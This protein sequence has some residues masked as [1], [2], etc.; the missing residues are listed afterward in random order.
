LRLHEWHKRWK[1]DKHRKA[2]PPEGQ[3]EMPAEQEQPRDAVADE[4][5]LTRPGTRVRGPARLPDIR[6]AKKQPPSIGTSPPFRKPSSDQDT[7]SE[8]PPAAEVVQETKS[9]A[10]EPA[11]APRRPAARTSRGTGGRFERGRA[12]AIEQ[13]LARIRGTAPRPVPEAPLVEEEPD[14]PEEVPSDVEQQAIQMGQRAR[15]ILSAWRT[16]Q[17]SLPLDIEEPKPKR[18]RPR[19]VAESRGS[20]IERLLDPELTLQETAILLNVCPSTVRRYTDKGILGHHRTPGN[21]RRF[22]LSDVLEFMDASRK[23]PVKHAPQRAGA[24][25]SVP[26]SAILSRG[27]QVGRE[28]SDRG[29]RPRSRTNGEH[30]VGKARV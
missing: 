5:V 12:L 24:D 26:A 2:G 29:R 7:T 1:T 11:R 9:A 8:A 19:T 15:E 13:A 30:A 18:G 4:A 23:G 14:Q 25:L 16:R 17:G 27:D 22:R 20:L 10:Q 6:P 28:D 21:Q 3:D